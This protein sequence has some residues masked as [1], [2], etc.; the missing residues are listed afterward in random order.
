M[1]KQPST[2]LKHLDKVADQYQ[3]LVEKVKLA[4]DK[5][6]E[7]EAALLFRE[8][9]RLRPT[10]LR[11]LDQAEAYKNMLVRKNKRSQEQQQLKQTVN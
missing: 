6:D 8:I 7:A 1:K 9:M 3:D 2:L 4:L 11:V 10:C 5:G